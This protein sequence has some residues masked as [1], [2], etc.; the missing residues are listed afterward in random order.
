MLFMLLCVILTST[1][2]HWLPLTYRMTWLGIFTDIKG[3][4]ANWIQMDNWDN[5]LTFREVS[6]FYSDQRKSDHWLRMTQLKGVPSS[7]WPMRQ[8]VKFA[9]LLLVVE[10]RFCILYKLFIYKQSRGNFLWNRNY[11]S[12]IFSLSVIEEIFSMFIL[13]HF[14]G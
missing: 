5:C 4:P 11:V 7:L 9:H 13:F 14:R 10:T 8:K 3:L 12:L 2:P 6:T 1:L